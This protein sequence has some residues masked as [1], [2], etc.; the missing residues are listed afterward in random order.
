MRRIRAVKLWRQNWTH[1]EG[2]GSELR[3]VFSPCRTLR[4]VSSGR[5]GPSGEDEYVYGS[6][7]FQTDSETQSGLKEQF[8]KHSDPQSSGP[9]V[10]V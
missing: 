2:A 7:S 6:F 10:Q 1:D 3:V 4:C 9:S 5:V 8:R